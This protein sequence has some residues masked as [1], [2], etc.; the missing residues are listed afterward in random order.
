MAALETSGGNS[1]E[2][3]SGL[4][5]NEIDQQA[6]GNQTASLAARAGGNDILKHP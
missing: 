1:S 6:D 4:V 2:G 3:A 5:I